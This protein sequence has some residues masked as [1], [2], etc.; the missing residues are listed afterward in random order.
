MKQD[1]HLLD[2]YIKHIMAAIE[3]IQRYCADANELAF[4]EN[5]ML[6]DAV[7]RVLHIFNQHTGR[8]AISNL[9]LAK[10]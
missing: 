6:Q 5:D 4:L 10:L 1:P 2:D 8:I 7:I 3:R 9:T